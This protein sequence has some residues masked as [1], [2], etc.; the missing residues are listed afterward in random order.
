MKLLVGTGRTPVLIRSLSFLIGPIESAQHGRGDPAAEQRYAKPCADDGVV[1]RGKEGVRR[2]HKESAP[3]AGGRRQNA[4]RRTK[5]RPRAPL[6]AS[7]PNS[8]I[9]GSLLAVFGMLLGAVVVAGASPLV[10]TGGG[11]VV[12]GGAGAG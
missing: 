1:C 12:A 9:N 2:G 5:C 10:P 4:R 11:A 3:H 6:S 8:A 7:R